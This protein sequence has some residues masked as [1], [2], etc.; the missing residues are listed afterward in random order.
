[1]FEVPEKLEKYSD[2]IKDINKNINW[3][4]WKNKGFEFDEKNKCPFCAEEFS[5]SYT[6]EKESFL[7]NYTKASMKNLSDI[8]DL[9]EGIKNYLDLDQYNKLI[10]CIKRK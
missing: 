2:F 10:S 3:V 9:I 6:E 5:Q 7:E 8:L 4:D 1:M